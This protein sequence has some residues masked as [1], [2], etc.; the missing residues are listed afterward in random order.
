MSE[1]HQSSTGLRWI[2]VFVALAVVAILA[3]LLLPKVQK[4]GG[5]NRRSQSR[6]N[7]KY[8]GLALHNYHDAHKVFPPGL[9][10]DAADSYLAGADCE[11]PYRN[12]ASGLTL[13]LPFMEERQVYEA[14]NQ[15]H[16]ACAETNATAVTSVAKTLL[17]PRFGQDEPLPSG[18]FPSGVARTDYVLC[19]GSNAVLSPINR[20]MILTS[21]YNW[22]GVPLPYR[23]GAGMFDVNSSV[24]IRTVRDG[25]SNTFMAGE[26]V[27]G[28]DWQAASAVNGK[29]AY[30]DQAWAQDRIPG[31]GYD[32]PFGSVFG[33]TAH[34][35]WHATDLILTAPDNA[36]KRWTPQPP[37]TGGTKPVPPSFYTAPYGE[38]VSFDPYHEDWGGSAPPMPAIRTSGFHS[39][40]N[41]VNML[42]ADGSARSL[43]ADVDPRAWAA[44]ATVA[45]RETV[46]RESGR[47]RF[48]MPKPEPKETDR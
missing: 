8:I 41:V 15:R 11:N 43:T 26:A 47:Y 46:T 33:V 36:V 10:M 12:G 39:P 28:P 22:T 2:N 1:S 40:G 32:G 45:G 27:G 23:W 35:A 6:N 38:L 30:V 24:G 34:D 4:T 42:M 20:F 25:T 29:H 31:P 5:G 16:R 44:L 21:P 7:L 17:Y 48:E 37:V 13:I 14:Y 3:T 9:T 19:S 18:Y